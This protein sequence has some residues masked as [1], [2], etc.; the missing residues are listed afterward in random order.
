MRL[1]IR[2]ISAVIVVLAVLLGM[3]LI[4][5]G[6]KIATLAADQLEKQ[7]GRKLEF[8]G[9]VRFTFWPTL[10][11]KADGVTLANADWAGSEPLLKAERLT[12]GLAAADL[13]RGDVRITEISA[14]LPVLNLTTRED[15]VGNWVFAQTRSNTSPAPQTDTDDAL[16]ISIERVS[17]TGATLRYAPHGGETIEMNQIDVFADWPDPLGT[18]EV[19]LT[20][21]PAGEA[22]RLRG[23]IGTFAQFLGG[24][25]SS[26]GMIVEAGGGL[27]R[28]DGNVNLAGEAQGRVTSEAGDLNAVLAALG[29]SGALPAG[30]GP[31]VLLA[32]DLTYTAAGQ[33]S[34]RD[35]LVGI[36]KNQF[37]G[38][39]DLM[40][41]DARPKLTAQLTANALDFSSL[42][43]TQ[44]GTAS[45]TNTP[46]TS[47]WSKDIIDASALALLDAQVGLRFDSLKAGDLTLGTS[48]LTLTIDRARAVVTMQPMTA[49][50]GTIQGDLVANNRNG[51]S[52]GGKLSFNN[53][54][55]EQALG[56]L[57]GFDNMNGSVLGELNFLGVGNSVDA[58]I[59]SLSGDGW[60][61]VGKGFYT[62]FDLEALMRAGRGNGGST[63]FDS[64]SASFTLAD[65][66]AQNSDLSA[67]VKGASVAGEGRVMLSA[68][69]L[70]YLFKPTL[71]RD[72]HAGLT[73][74]VS[75]TGPWA[76]P[77]IRPDLEGALK[78]RLDELETEV[79]QDAEDKLR[80]KLGEELNT[81]IEPEQNLNDVLKDRIE[82]EAKEQL[83]KLLGGN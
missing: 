26:V 62:G 76:N 12:I 6:E 71:A 28:F 57:A 53:V 78:P 52:V 3:V 64:L 61:E 13:L 37:R 49:F 55:L 75:V 36:G 58:I 46:Q 47:G 83:L 82:Q 81:V 66:V 63:V 24:A 29:Q 19:D 9:P 44:A 68:Q 79:K 54:L 56:Q 10:G 74:P 77:K 50:G 43:L 41:S 11:M 42:V 60:F 69:A 48:A 38:A 45:A 40:T 5:P 22:V 65:G 35:M 30:V 4:L 67:Q 23:E 27:T 1:I 14:I 21:R 32:A 33:L 39:L 73:I 80:E 7:T 16:P 8:A 34:L 2:V 70:D 18:A 20:I 15:G 51:L 25:V 31:D 17:L 72:G 59:R